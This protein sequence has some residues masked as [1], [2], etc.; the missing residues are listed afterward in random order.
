MNECQNGFSSSCQT[1]QIRNEAHDEFSSNTCAAAN[2]EEPPNTSDTKPLDP[3]CL[4]VSMVDIE[5]EVGLSNYLSQVTSPS[6]EVIG[7][8]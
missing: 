8:A 5:M 1:K 4:S 3:D 6:S 2:K 7:V